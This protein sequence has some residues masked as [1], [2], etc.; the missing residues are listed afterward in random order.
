MLHDVMTRHYR[1]T[2]NCKILGTTY[3]K[4]TNKKKTT[5]YEEKRM[6]IASS[7]RSSFLLQLRSQQHSLH[8]LT[9]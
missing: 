9:L 7:I 4:E 6:L 1:L 2:L 3:V 8:T 5:F